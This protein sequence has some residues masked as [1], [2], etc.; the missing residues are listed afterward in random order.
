MDKFADAVSL[1]GDIFLG[2]PNWRSQ[3][4]Q[5]LDRILGTAKCG[6]EG[7]IMIPSGG[8]GGKL[9]LARHD[10]AT[11]AA[12]VSGFC[13]HFGMA[14][15][16]CVG[17]LPLHHV[18]GF[19][20]WMRCALTGGTYLHWDWKDLE[21]GRYPADVPEQCCL[22]LV[23][24]QL[25]RLLSS[26]EA[27]AWL[28]R[29]AVIF[30]GGG[31]AWAALVEKVAVLGLRLSPCYGATETAAMAAALRPGDF[32]S[33]VR[34]CGQALPHMGIDFVDGVVRISGESLFK[35]YY[36]GR[37]V[38]RSWLTE[39]LGGFNAAGSLVI[40]GRRDSVIVTGG[41]KVSPEEVESVLRQS[42]EFQDVTVIG[43][44]DEHWGEVVV[45]CYPEGGR[46]P[47]LA[48]VEEALACL[49]PF[50]RP[51]RYLAVSPWPRNA[52]GK[53]DFE[54]LRRLASRA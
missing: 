12:A 47:R 20:A 18:S 1:G 51:K 26:E 36:P 21:G 11:I 44:P 23:P 8:S 50:K 3:E 19:M 37:S 4:R 39:D 17:V 34:G 35:G 42:S 9:K 41:S 24:T 13:R 5:E 15:V 46:A 54:S 32:L 6:P 33:G 49:A 16:N 38:S 2:N 40:L 27:V 31:P 53:I 7:W 48:Q 52:Q 10:G 30:V 29:F 43:L 22:S 25:L 14:R 45:A 28:R